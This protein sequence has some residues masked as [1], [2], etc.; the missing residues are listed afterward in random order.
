MDKKEFKEWFKIYKNYITIGILSILLLIICPFIGGSFLGAGFVFPTT[1]VGWILWVGTKLATAAVNIVIFDSFTKQGKLNAKQTPE[2][3]EAER[4]LSLIEPE[5][6]FIPQ[7]PRVIESKSYLKKSITLVITSLASTFMISQAILSFDW[8][9]MIS[10]FITIVLGIV[11]GLNQQA[12]MEELWSEDYLK[13]AKYK[14][15]QNEKNM[16]ISKKK[17]LEQGNDITNTDS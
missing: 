4:L 9:Q 3:K 14:E 5:K 16:E 10:Y 15:K 13:Y 17:L 1:A 11:F 8:I 6:E 7:D 2:Y 12:N